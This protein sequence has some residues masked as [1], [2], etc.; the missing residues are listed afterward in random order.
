MNEYKKTET[1]LQIQRKNQWLWKVEGWGR[2]DT[3]EG[4]QMY[5]PSG[6]TE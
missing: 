3:G 2:G 1:N 5:K 4:D 6:S